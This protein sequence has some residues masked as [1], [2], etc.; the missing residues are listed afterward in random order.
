MELAIDEAR[1]E[2]GKFRDQSK[3]VLFC[4]MKSVILVTSEWESRGMT[5]RRHETTGRWFYF[6][7]TVVRTLHAANARLVATELILLIPPNLLVLLAPRL[8]LPA[9]PVDLWAA[10]EGFA[11]WSHNDTRV[12]TYGSSYK[13]YIIFITIVIIIIHINH[14][15][16]VAT[17]LCI[18]KSIR[19]IKHGKIVCTYLS[20]S[21]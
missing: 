2:V 21:S 13:C 9:L 14:T 4:V 5:S 20:L 15:T 12:L 8:L 1:A 11:A 16:P 3:V 17:I 19:F 6:S 7:H 18:T 10:R